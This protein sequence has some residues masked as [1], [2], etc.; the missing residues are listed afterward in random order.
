MHQIGA[1]KYKD[2]DWEFAEEFQNRVSDKDTLETMASFFVTDPEIVCGKA[3]LSDILEMNN[4]D[5]VMPGSFDH[6]D[7]SYIAPFA[8][9]AVASFFPG[10]GGHT[11]QSTACAGS[12]LGEDALMCATKVLVGSIYDILQNP[13][14][15][16]SA[17]EEF[18]KKTGGKPYVSSYEL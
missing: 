1:P 14:I 10:C 17:K 3:M 9:L 2:E 12:G 16:K 18:Q 6:G 4:W 11:W 13:E 5:K 8:Y 7:V 15:L